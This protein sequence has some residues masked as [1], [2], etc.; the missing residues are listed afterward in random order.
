MAAL[1]FAAACASRPH[2]PVADA[3]L[4]STL[5]L[6]TG[7]DEKAYYLR[8]NCS[9]WCTVPACPWNDCAACNFCT[10]PRAVEL[11]PPS[12]IPG[13]MSGMKSAPTMTPFH[14][15]HPPPGGCTAVLVVPGG[16]FAFIEEYEAMPPAWR[17]NSM[18]YSTFRLDY[19]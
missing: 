1:L 6:S 3:L 5:S 13:N 2:P 15:T 9:A 12:R 18:G 7:A 4:P 11:F 19:R 17:L 8:R 10:V 14:C 16:G